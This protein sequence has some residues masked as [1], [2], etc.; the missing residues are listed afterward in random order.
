MGMRMIVEKLKTGRGMEMH[1]R[2]PSALRYGYCCGRSDLWFRCLSRLARRF[3]W[4]VL[5]PYAILYI[6]YIRHLRL[7][8]GLDGVQG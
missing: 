3:H 4:R 6:L 8:I 2:K 5:Q 1:Y 7:C